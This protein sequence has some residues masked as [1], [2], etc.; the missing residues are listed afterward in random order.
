MMVLGYFILRFKSWDGLKIFFSP[1]LPLK[2]NTDTLELDA[3]NKAASVIYLMC[4]HILKH[5]DLISAEIK[6]VLNNK[7]N[8]IFLC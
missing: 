7:A 4:L 2:I 6:T 1:F 3:R 5:C 8:K